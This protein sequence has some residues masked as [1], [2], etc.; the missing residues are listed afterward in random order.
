[1]P[2]GAAIGGAV[3][4]GGASLLAAHTQASGAQAAANTSAQAQANATA[5]Q[6]SM[7][8]QTR[9]DLQPF[10]QTGYGALSA[11]AS[12]LGPQGP[13]NSTLSQLSDLYGKSGPIS[14]LLGTSPQGSAG[15][16]SQLQNYPGYQFA[17]DQGLQALDRSAASRGMLLSGGQLKDAQQFGQGL[18]DQTYGTYLSQLEGFGSGLGGLAS[19]YGTYGNEIAGVVNTGENAGAQ[20]GNAGS[21]AASGIS[22]ALIQGSANQAQSQLAAGTAGASGIAGAANQIGG[23]LNNQSLLAAI[24]APNYGGQYNYGSDMSLT[25]GADF[26]PSDRRLKTNIEKVGKLNSGLS[27]YSYRLKGSPRT[28]LGVMADEVR[29]VAPDAVRRAPDG[30]DRV[31]YKKVSQLQPLKR[32]A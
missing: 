31:N 20:T 29:R 6:L 22:N 15:M 7:Y 18:A 1:M 8:N 2:I 23:L 21:A 13:V 19:Q 14:T 24:N 27:V 3:I 25:S 11:L 17:R 5:A 16:Q 12:F 10:T 32:A 28:Q 26:L 9:S 4:G 30:F